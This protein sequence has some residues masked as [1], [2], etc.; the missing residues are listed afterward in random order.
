[1]ARDY[2]AHGV[3]ARARSL[4]TFELGPETELERI[5]KLVN[6]MGQ[7]RLTGLDRALLAHTKDGILVVTSAL[8]SDPTQHTLRIGRLR[9]LERLGL[10]EER[11]AG[12]WA[13]DPR[14]ETKLRQLGERADKFKMM[15]RALKQAGIDRATSAMCVVRSGLAQDPSD[16]QT[17]WGWV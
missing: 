2:I 16:R 6:E 17:R 13:V 10:A 15:Q 1:M 4:I 9:T 5:Q 7:E 8:S 11:Q 3:R 12:V 14:T